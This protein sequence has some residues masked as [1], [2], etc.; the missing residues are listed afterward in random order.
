M[1]AQKTD[2]YIV[3][4]SLSF[5][6]ACVAQKMPTKHPNYDTNILINKIA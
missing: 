5:Y 6:V 2:I 4:S 1:F 3:H